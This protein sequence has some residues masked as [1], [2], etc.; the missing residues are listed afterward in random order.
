A[1]KAA[2]FG[3][4]NG[5][6]KFEGSPGGPLSYGFLANALPNTATTTFTPFLTAQIPGTSTTETLAGVYNNAGREQLEISFGYNF[7]Q[8]QYRYIAHGIV[9]WITRGVHFGYWR[10]YFDVHIDDVFSY[11]SIW[12]DTGKCTP[13]E[14][15][16]DA[17]T[18]PVRMGAGDVTS[19]VT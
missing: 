16:C 9:D 12:S 5:T 14:G 8:L 4:L 11:D 19:A 15:I 17:T 6:F 13:G 10:N 3:Y 7:Y 18:T 1:A 2:G